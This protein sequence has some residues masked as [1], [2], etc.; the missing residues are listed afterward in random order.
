MDRQNRRPDP[1]WN[2]GTV[3]Q[4]VTEWPVHLTLPI[5]KMAQTLGTK[6]RKR[7]KWFRVIVPDGRDG[8]SVDNVARD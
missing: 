7:F 2:A 1:A 3:R 4:H 5:F 8:L 6:A